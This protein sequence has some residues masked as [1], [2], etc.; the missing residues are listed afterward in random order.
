MA[1]RVGIPGIGKFKGK[2]LEVGQL[3]LSCVCLLSR[4]GVV[5]LRDVLKGL[6][7]LLEPKESDLS[8]SPVVSCPRRG[9]CQGT[10]LETLFLKGNWLMDA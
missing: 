1:V 9:T 6:D 8:T 5:V 10:W 3:S 2:V 7:L 4:A